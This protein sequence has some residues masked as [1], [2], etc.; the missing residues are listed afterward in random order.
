MADLQR[1]LDNERERLRVKGI[2][3]AVA[4]TA[5]VVWVGSSGKSTETTPVASEMLF[6][7]GS[8][9]KTYVG[10]L[11]MKLVDEGTLSLEDPVGRWVSRL[12]HI[13]P[14]LTVRQLLNHTSGLYRYQIKPEYLA[15]IY[16]QPQRVWAAQEIVD[17]FQGDPEQRPESSW[18]ESALDYVLL[19]MIVEKGTGASV[20]S[21]L[22][23]RLFT[24]LGL[25][26]TF[27]YPD[28]RYPSERMAHMW[29]DVAGTGHP[30]DVVAGAGEPPLGGLF[31]S[32]WTSGAL[33]ATA[34]DLA[35]FTHALFSGSVLSPRALREMLAPGPE[36][37]TGI[38]YGF[39]VIIER[40]KRGATYWHSGGAGYSSIYRYSP[41]QNRSVA[42]LCNQMVDLRS[43]AD[44]LDR[45]LAE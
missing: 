3:A 2:S 17:Q 21:V 45:G 32:L 42:V 10:A 43:L 20:S 38:G 22:R 28:E 30:V 13:D 41:E 44:A 26:S 11:V 14:G 1:E 19:G 5:G 23:H 34:S 27:L 4:T 16:Q 33:H 24:P 12:G 25:E 36:L 29:W 15:A 7:L 31:S 35:R 18:G 6:G 37:G 8:V 39:S 40:T 9:T